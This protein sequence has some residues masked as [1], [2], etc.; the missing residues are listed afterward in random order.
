ADGTT[1]AVIEIQYAGPSENFAWMLPVQGRPE[2]AVSSTLAFDRLQSATAPSYRLTTR[3]EGACAPNGPVRQPDP[4]AGDDVSPGFQDAGAAELAPSP[5]DV[6]VVD[7]GSVGPYDF[8]IINVR[9]DAENVGAIATDWLSENGYDVSEFGRDRLV[10]YLESGMNLLA[11]R[12]SKGQNTGAIRP[13]RLSFGEGLPSIPLR[14][15]AAATVPNMGILVWVIGQARAIPANYRDLELNEA[16]LDWFNTGTSYTALVTAAA[17]EAGGQ[18]FVTEMAGDASP[19]NGT[20]YDDVD[21]IE[22]E[23]LEAALTRSPVVHGSVLAVTLRAFSTWDGYLEVIRAEVPRPDA[24]P[25]D[26]WQQNTQRYLRGLASET[27]IEGFDPESFVARL[28]DEVVNPVRETAA[29]FAD[30]RTMTRFFTTMSS[31]EMTVDPIFDFNEDLPDY[32]NVHSRERVL[33]CAPSVTRAEAPWRVE[34]DDGLVVRGLNRFWPIRRLNDEM[35]ANL[36]VRRVGNEGAGDIIT[37]NATAILAAAETSNAA[38]PPPPPGVRPRREPP[39][40]DPGSCGIID[41]GADGSDADGNIDGG[42]SSSPGGAVSGGSCAA[43]HTGASLTSLLLLT[44]FLRR[45]RS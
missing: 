9:P 45:R 29:L 42:D 15:T 43:G 19:M 24:V 21:Q 17:N 11:F 38:F 6:T 7:S 18:A 26:E 3:T 44:F 1:T 35:P 39:S 23:R 30:D 31:D 41:G 12:L 2:I 32:S 13:V 16:R 20:I 33:E 36:R 40:R 37:D 34:F 10:P 27:T 4:C 5:P 14:P 28:T 22:F 8:V 25:E